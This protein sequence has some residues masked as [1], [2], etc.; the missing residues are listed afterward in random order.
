MNLH[1]GRYGSSPMGT[2]GILTVN[3]YSWFTVERPWKGNRPSVSCVPHGNYQMVWLPTTT[4]VP[5]EFD[6]HTWYLDGE[7][8]SPYHE[9]NKP[10]SRCAFHIANTQQDVT[11][12]IGV[13]RFLGR[14]GPAWA[15]TSSLV[16]LQELLGAIG[17]GPH[18][19]QIEPLLSG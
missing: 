5:A 8:V 13:G 10:R 16:A 19:L 2:F 7:T 6:G 18:S 9:S 11:G 17:P 1:L 4:P 14:I 15:V 3:A 12:C